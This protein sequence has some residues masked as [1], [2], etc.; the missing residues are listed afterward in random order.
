M[1]IFSMSI[2]I[3]NI[4]INV[5]KNQKKTEPIFIFSCVWFLEILLYKLRLFGMPELSKEVEIIVLLAIVL[6]TC[7]SF[8]ARHIVLHKRQNISKNIVNI[9][10][11]KSIIIKLE[12]VAF[13]IFLYGALVD[14][15]S[16]FRGVSMSHYRYLILPQIRTPLYLSMIMYIAN[17]IFYIAIM[18]NIYMILAKK[19][20]FRDVWIF[21][22]LFI[23]AILYSGGGR[24][25]FLLIVIALWI[26]SS[27]F[28]RY[29]L[30][31]STKRKVWLFSFIFAGLIIVVSV[32]RGSNW[33]SELYS[34]FVCGLPNMDVH[35]KL[36]K[37][38]PEYC[39]G[40]LSVQGFFRPIYIILRNLGVGVINNV[41]RGY[42]LIDQRMY[43]EGMGTIN[44]TVTMMMYFYYDGGLIG[45]SL[46]SFI[47]GFISQKAY[48]A[49]CVKETL[50]KLINY[51]MVAFMIVLSFMQISTAH[52][53]CAFVFYWIF[54]IRFLSKD[55][56]YNMI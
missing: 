2:C 37:Q 19:S 52:I 22:T 5:I 54:I 26:S 16:I 41:D 51:I 8:L 36:F 44:S 46:L 56:D 49:F 33:T 30:N 1:L 18:Y 14:L 27:I 31:K 6:F 13:V 28:P 34:Y 38:N 39:G 42:T 7:G 25:P 11:S 24:L 12:I 55:N 4:V 21:I 32:M 17:P 43:I 3:F 29:Q 53:E 40:L 48:R 10:I 35:I 45:V 15:I 23:T 20:N 47:F 50:S 9:D